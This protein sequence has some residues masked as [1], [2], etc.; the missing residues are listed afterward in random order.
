MPRRLLSAALLVATVLTPTVLG[1]LA[2]K[3]VRVEVEEEFDGARLAIIRDPPTRCSR[4]EG[5]PYTYD[6]YPFDTCL[7]PDFRYSPFGNVLI[8]NPGRC[9]SDG[10][11]PYLAIYTTTSDCT[12][13]HYRPAWFD[14]D[15]TE[16]PSFLY[17]YGLPICL[18][19]I[20]PRAPEFPEMPLGVPQGDWSMV[21]RCTD[22]EE[23]SEAEGAA[24]LMTISLPPA[25]P[26][27]YEK[28]E[29]HDWR[30][31]TI[32][33]TACRVPGLEIPTHLKSYPMPDTCLEIAPKRKLAIMGLPVCEGG[34]QSRLARYRGTGCRGEPTSITKITWQMM[35][36]WDTYC[37]DMDNDEEAAS[38]SFYCE[39]TKKELPSSDG[40]GSSVPIESHKTEAKSRPGRPV[41]VSNPKSSSGSGGEWIQWVVVIPFFLLFIV[42]L[43]SF[44]A[45]IY[46]YSAIFFSVL[47]V[48]HFHV[49]SRSRPTLRHHYDTNRDHSG[50]S[51]SSIVRVGRA[52]LRCSEC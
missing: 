28:P 34:L 20:L 4:D 22:K 5:V 44:A 7:S 25:L 26:A 10:K 27:D 13:R 15:S 29:L 33:D 17:A 39:G 42:I 30:S 11:A 16:V 43:G 41:A 12:G 37:I 19:N 21:F 38:Y 47:N 31:G 32:S 48:S 24:A 23:A 46:G 51:C 9:K 1:E 52:R 35:G 45:I 36:S 8:V 18:S 49:L 40:I 3:P 50:L 14:P 2:P 6:V